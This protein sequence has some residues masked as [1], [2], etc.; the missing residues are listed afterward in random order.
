MVS[1]EGEVRE[2]QSR[3]NQLQ[4]SLHSHSHTASEFAAQRAQVVELQTQVDTFAGMRGFLC[5]F[6][7]CMCEVS[8]CRMERLYDV[9]IVCG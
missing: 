2:H 9:C 4:A 7:L 8:M 5:C 1:L 6:L 3:N